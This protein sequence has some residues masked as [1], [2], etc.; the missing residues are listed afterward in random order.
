MPSE[1]DYTWHCDV[2]R[3][4][5]VPFYVTI[6][7]NLTD[8]TNYPVT[9]FVCRATHLVNRVIPCEARFT[10]LSKFTFCVDRWSGSEHWVFAYVA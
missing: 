1:M 9:T 8:G 6:V 4:P 3:I 7:C 2:R 10:N 5:R